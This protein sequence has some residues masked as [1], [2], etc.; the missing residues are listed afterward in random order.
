M[1][2]LGLV[3][4]LLKWLVYF[5]GWFILMIIGIVFIIFAANKLTG[6]PKCGSRKPFEMLAGGR[7]ARACPECGHVIAL[8]SDEE[9][10][11]HWNRISHG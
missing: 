11:D 3:A 2:T 4:V 8:M 7:C 1:K 9:G 5:A 6:C 10:R